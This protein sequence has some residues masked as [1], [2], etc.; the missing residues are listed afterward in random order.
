ME[1]VSL[2]GATALCIKERRFDP[3]SSVLL[4]M[5]EAVA[6]DGITHHRSLFSLFGMLA[7]S[8]KIQLVNESV[9]LIINRQSSGFLPMDFLYACIVNACSSFPWMMC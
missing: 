8:G 1:K 5:V 6:A 4:A 7:D 9:M 3:K 2:E